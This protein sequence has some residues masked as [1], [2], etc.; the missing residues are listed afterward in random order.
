MALQI[1]HPQ[2]FFYAL[3]AVFFTFFTFIAGIAFAASNQLAF[4]LSL[5][6]S[7]IF[8]VTLAI[9]CYVFKWVEFPAPAVRER[10]AEVEP[11]NTVV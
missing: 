4:G 8:T 3:I 9:L 5:L 2:G 10:Q 7:N 11:Q 1:T 6:I